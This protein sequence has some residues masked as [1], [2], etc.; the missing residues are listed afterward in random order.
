MTARRSFAEEIKNE[1][2]ACAACFAAAVPHDEGDG[3]LGVFG[4]DP[5]LRVSFCEHSDRCGGR[6]RRLT[7]RGYVKAGAVRIEKRDGVW[8][9]VPR[10]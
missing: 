10:E 8:F 4:T 1:T 5:Y 2:G 9:W 7:K 3:G 6:I